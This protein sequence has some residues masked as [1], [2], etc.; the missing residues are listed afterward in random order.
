MRR[1]LAGVSGLLSVISAASLATAQTSFNNVILGHSGGAAPSATCAG[2]SSATSYG[3]WPAATS[4]AISEVS[5]VARFEV[6][7]VGM[8]QRRSAQVG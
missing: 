5:S 2:S 1:F 8:A 3:T 7:R 4:L 6:A